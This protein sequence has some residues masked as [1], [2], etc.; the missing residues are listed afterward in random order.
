[1]R[2][3]EDK[4]SIP[5]SVQHPSSLTTFGCGSSS[6]IIANSW[7]RSRFSDSE[8]LAFSILTAT[9]VEPIVNK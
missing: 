5:F 1:M 4:I 7:S 8:A 9:V 6:F 3:I 2:L